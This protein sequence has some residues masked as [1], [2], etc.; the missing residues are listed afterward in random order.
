VLCLNDSDHLMKEGKGLQFC[1]RQKDEA[2]MFQ[3][4]WNA[5][6]GW[7]YIFRAGIAHGV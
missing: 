1:M 3:C 5:E 2:S 7:L 6:T 4:S